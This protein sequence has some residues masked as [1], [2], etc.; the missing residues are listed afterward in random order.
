MF[1]YSILNLLSDVSG[2]HRKIVFFY[3][4][5]R[6]LSL[7]F[8]SVVGLD[9]DPHGST[10]ILVG[11]IRECGSGSKRAK[12]TNKSFGH[13]KPGSDPTLDSYPFPDAH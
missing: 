6:Q 1:F 2:Y 10:F 13:Q 3:G 7:V 12:M 11:R 9:L 5:F 4:Y 8:Y